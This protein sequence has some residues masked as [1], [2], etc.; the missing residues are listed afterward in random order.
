MRL[1]S[2]VLNAPILS[3]IP[4]IN[5]ESFCTWM[6]MTTSKLKSLLNV[7]LVV[8]LRQFKIFLCSSLMKRLIFSLSHRLSFKMELWCMEF[9]GQ[10]LKKR[11]FK[12]DKCI[13][14]VLPGS[15][16][17]LVYN[18][19][20]ECKSLI[21]NIHGPVKYLSVTCKHLGS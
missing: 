5:Q 7:G 8:G 16:R 15:T 21:F 12:T 10:F 3:D 1:C 6:N 2:C 9:T 18:N 11:D 4:H 17:T 19:T 13:F 14:S 20:Q